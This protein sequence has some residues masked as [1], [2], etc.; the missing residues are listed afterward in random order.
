M[1]CASIF[2]L[3][4]PEGTHESGTPGHTNTSAGMSVRGHSSEA[5]L[6]G[7]MDRPCSL[8]TATRP[9]VLDEDVAGEGRLLPRNH[10]AALWAPAPACLTGSLTL[11]RPQLGCQANHSCCAGGGGKARQTLEGAGN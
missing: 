3:A 7:Q 5:F 6:S 8:F 10:E 4:S 11:F 1:G 2:Y 9:N